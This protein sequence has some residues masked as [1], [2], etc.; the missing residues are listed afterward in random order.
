MP[1]ADSLLADAC[2]SKVA[3][4][5]NRDL[6]VVIAQ[7]LA[8]SAGMTAN[9]LLEAACTSRI[10]CLG[11]RDLLVVIAEAIAQGG[12][13]GPGGT[14]QVYEGR[15]PAN[16]DDPTKAAVSFESGGG[17]LLQWSVIA[18]AWV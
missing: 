8:D 12:G 17:T 6:L 10:A 9:E 7:A 13:S 14:I 3:C 1:S 2:E 15:A 5:Q 11:E 16:P 18:Q 4:L